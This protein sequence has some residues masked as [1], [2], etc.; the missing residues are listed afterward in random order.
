MIKAVLKAT[1]LVV[2]ASGAGG[3][4]CGCCVQSLCRSLAVVVM[5]LCTRGLHDDLS[6]KDEFPTTSASGESQCDTPNVRNCG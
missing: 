2:L 1:K 5:L 3:I 4:T 6:L